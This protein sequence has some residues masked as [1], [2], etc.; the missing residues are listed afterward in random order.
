MNRLICILTSALPLILVSEMP[1]APPTDAEIQAAI[2]QLGDEK[3]AVREKAMKLLLRAGPAAEAAVREVLYSTN[4]EVAKRARILLDR[5]TYRIEPDTP[6]EIVALIQKFRVGSTDEQTAA[7]K[8]LLKIGTKS[9][10][11]ILRLVDNVDAIRLKSLMEQFALDDWKILAVLMAGGQEKLVEELLYRAMSAGFED[12][13]THDAVLRLLS[14][15]ID[16]TIA[17]LRAEIAAKGGSQS[18]RRLATLYRIKGDWDGVIWAAER[19]EASELVRLALME[20]GKWGELLTRYTPVPQGGLNE[21]HA[22]GLLAAYQR[23]AG[24]TAEFR[25]S[26]KKIEEYA[27]RQKKDSQPFYAAKALMINERNQDAIDLLIKYEQWQQAADLLAAQGKF[28]AAIALSEKAARTETQ[29]NFTAR[30]THINLLHRLGAVAKGCEWLDNL[31]KDMAAVT[32]G[33]WP[34]RQIELEYRLGRV[35]SAERHLLE[36]IERDGANYL[37]HAFEAAFLQLAERGDTIWRLIRYQNPNERMDDSLKRL[38]KIE[39]K[40][41][42]AADL[43]SLLRTAVPSAEWMPKNSS[44]SAFDHLASIVEWYGRADLAEGMLAN[45]HWKDAPASARLTLADT[46]ADAGKWPQAA[47]AY[48]NIWETDRAA[49][50]PYFLYGAAL[51]QTGKIDEGKQI[52][53]TAHRMMLGAGRDRYYFHDAILDR[54]YVADAEREVPIRAQLSSPTTGAYYHGL[55]QDRAARLAQHRGDFLTAAAIHER[56]LLRLLA[57]NTGLRNS[58]GYMRMTSLIHALRAKGLLAQGK[59][60]DAFREIETARQL[61]PVQIEIPILLVADLEKAGEKE[62]AA[63]LFDEIYAAI[64]HSSRDFPGCADAHNQ[65]AWMAVRCRRNALIHSQKAVELAPL[66]VSYLDTLAEVHFQ[67]GDTAKAIELMKRCLKMP[68]ANMAFYRQ[69]L[70]RFEK[71][72]LKVEPADE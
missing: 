7:I 62:R 69:Q 27:G 63:K 52:M 21:I 35:E 16:P 44:P 61:D 64:E 19:G 50:L 37:G 30:M 10:S 66:T 18:A 51:A 65:V 43:T 25:K 28:A 72:D 53:V 45:S 23:L 14:G 32:R 17:I 20:Q 46:L 36:L 56:N 39:D 1:A 29:P 38:R 55:A 15:E 49:A 22:L 13:C 9:H 3:F 31:V 57:I 2:K 24:N 41:I 47:S 33:S 60:D 11:Y 54:G 6:A 42:S 68:S 67:R 59:K 4:P 12:A 26:L 5:I 71:G 8:D 34:E 48:R 70:V 40:T 58:G